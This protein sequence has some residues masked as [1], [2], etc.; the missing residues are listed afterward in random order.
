MPESGNFKVVALP[1]P[2][3][4]PARC[5]AAI[6]V[7]T[8]D[9]SYK[10]QQKR[11]RKVF[12][13]WELPTLKAVFNDEKGEEPFTVFVEEK[14]S[15]HKES[16][17]AKL[18]AAWR[19]KP[20]TPEEKLAF[21]YS[22][23][24]NKTCLISFQV[25]TKSK[26]RDT[27]IS[28]AT[29]ENSSLKMGAISPLPKVMRETMPAIINPPVVWDWDK[30]IGGEEVFDV[31]KFKKIWKF[32]RQKMYTSDE[33]Q[34][35]PGRVNVDDEQGEAQQQVSQPVQQVAQPTQ[36]SQPTGPVQTEEPIDGDDW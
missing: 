5:I 25:K 3:T 8:V 30:I 29:N 21:D 10:D 27:D 19:N 34:E 35:C 14:F 6:D 23:M 33:W 11:D 17:F 20:L 7:G 9:N 15:G 2:E 16:N 36:P 32:V 22:T 24:V 1:K 12:I 26:Y 13:I 28:Q 31:E 4:V 18:I